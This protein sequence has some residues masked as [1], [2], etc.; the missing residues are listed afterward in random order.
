[1]KLRELR[2][3]WRRQAPASRL[4]NAI[5]HDFLLSVYTEKGW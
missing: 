4:N 2:S 1:M 5:A 3:N